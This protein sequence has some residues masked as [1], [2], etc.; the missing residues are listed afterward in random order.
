MLHPKMAGG[1]FMGF[2][3]IATLTALRLVH[4]VVR[5]SGAG[6]SGSFKKHCMDLARKISLLTHLLEEIRDSKNS[7]NNGEMGSSS[8]FNSCI[9]DLTLAIQAAKKLLFAA[10]NFDNSKISS[11]SIY[12]Y[13]DYCFFIYF[14]FMNLSFRDCMNWISKWVFCIFWLNCW[15]DVGSCY[16]CW[17]DWFLDLLSFGMGIDFYRCR[18]DLLTV[19]LEFLAIRNWKNG[20]IW[21]EFCRVVMWFSVRMNMHLAIL[22]NLG[23]RH[24][25][26]DN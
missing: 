19:V 11:V 8:S 20:L 17:F 26:L 4:D 16:F 21:S 15:N 12:I 2:A 3:D 1:E 22:L 10:N 7:H 13:M 6:F 5:I 24:N 14:C 23:R 9:S 25:K 18:F